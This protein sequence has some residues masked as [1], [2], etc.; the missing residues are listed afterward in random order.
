MVLFLQFLGFIRSNRSLHSYFGL[1]KSMAINVTIFSCRARF[2]W[3]R[4]QRIRRWVLHFL[5]WRGFIIW[6]KNTYRLYFIIGMINFWLG[7]Y[8]R[9][10]SLSRSLNSMV[11]SKGSL[12]KAFKWRRSMG[13]LLNKR[14]LIGVKVAIL[15]RLI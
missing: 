1:F 5:F 7:D 6:S 14:L 2:V 12:V 9:V 11:L 3:V 4:C 15:V 8:I 13:W 10:V